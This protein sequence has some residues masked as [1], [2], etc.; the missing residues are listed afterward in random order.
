MLVVSTVRDLTVAD[1]DVAR[2]MLELLEYFMR[3]DLGLG[4]S[5]RPCF[6]RALAVLLL[7]DRLDRVAGSSIVCSSLRLLSV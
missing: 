6:L 5:D 3:L 4:V 1:G 7:F 2:L